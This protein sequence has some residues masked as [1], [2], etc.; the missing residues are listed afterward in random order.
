[1]F[2]RGLFHRSDSFEIAMQALLGFRQASALQD[3]VKNFLPSTPQRTFSEGVTWL[4][5]IEVVQDLTEASA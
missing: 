1:M 3:V 4:R 5:G 2:I